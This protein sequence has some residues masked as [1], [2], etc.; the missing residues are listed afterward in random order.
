MA[1]LTPPTWLKLKE[2]A[3]YCCTVT[4]Q[5][6]RPIFISSSNETLSLWLKKWHEV[7]RLYYK[8]SPD[9]ADNYDP[10][11]THL[12]II[13]KSIYSVEIMDCEKLLGG[14]KLLFFSALS[15]AEAHECMTLLA[16]TGAVRFYLVYH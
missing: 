9:D 1:D 7:L 10:V 5:V 6:L 14:E 2:D 8:I 3:D 15:S 16:S 12:K 11:Y 4:M 13:N